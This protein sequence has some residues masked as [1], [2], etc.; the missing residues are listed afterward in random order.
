MRVIHC[1]IHYEQCYLTERTCQYSRTWEVWA[2]VVRHPVMGIPGGV[3][4]TAREASMA[5]IAEV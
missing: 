3:G 5:D 1:Q 2:T 4:I